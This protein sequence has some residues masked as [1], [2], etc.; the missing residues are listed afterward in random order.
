M[1]ALFGNFFTQKNNFAS[2]STDVQTLKNSC[3]FIVGE[4]IFRSLFF[5]RFKDWVINLRQL[6]FAI[7]QTVFELS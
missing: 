3:T 7:Y 4:R 1:D 6:S 2:L 5:I